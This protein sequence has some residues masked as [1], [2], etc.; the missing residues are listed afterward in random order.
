MKYERTNRRASHF[1]PNQ[2]W[3]DEEGGKE[4]GRRRESR[5]NRWR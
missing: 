5:R 3:T 2:R 1:T 4:G